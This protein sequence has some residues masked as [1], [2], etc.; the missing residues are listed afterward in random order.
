MDDSEEWWRDESRERASGRR[1]DRADSPSI[2]LIIENTRTWYYRGCNWNREDKQAVSVWMSEKD[3]QW[4]T[5]EKYLEREEGYR[6]SLTHWTFFTA[7]THRNTLTRFSEKPWKRMLCEVVAHY[8]K[9]NSI[10]SKSS[11]ILWR[12]LQSKRAKMLLRT[13]CTHKRT[14]ISGERC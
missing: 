14:F 12:E 7:T 8:F 6:L 2:R 9:R 5:G 3:P 4:L 11:N 1:S 13:T 10:K